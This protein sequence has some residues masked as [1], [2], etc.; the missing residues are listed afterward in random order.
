MIGTHDE[1]RGVKFI[2]DE[3]WI[4]I[5]VHGGHLE[6][7]PASLL[8][9]KI[10]PDEKQLG[11][12]RGHHRNFLNAVKTRQKTMA[13][14]EVGHH[15]ATICHLLNISMQL[16]GRRIK[17]NPKKEQVIDDSEASAMLTRPMRSPWHL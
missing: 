6:A 10:S 11:R 7:E 5:H 14:A 17:W 8:T 3:G 15:T 9:E 13:P 2:G 1:P 4:F 12:T 16:D